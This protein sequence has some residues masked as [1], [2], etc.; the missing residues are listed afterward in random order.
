MLRLDIP[1]SEFFDESTEEFYSTKPTTIQLEHSLVSLAKWEAEWEKP[2]LNTTDKSAEESLSY[3]RCMTITQ[4]V[5]PS[6]YTLIGHSQELVQKISEYINKPMTATT[7]TDKPR[8]RAQRVM[9]AELLY[10][11]MFALNI[12]IE[13]QK[14]HLNR[15]I[16]LIRVCSIESNPKKKMNRKDVA[17]YNH[18]LNQARRQKFHTRG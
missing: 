9:T 4:N 13:C 10:Y 8:G 17:S 1:A 15:L 7:I 2:F 12:P 18:A 16:M 5:D 14:W 3:I 11:D 6:V